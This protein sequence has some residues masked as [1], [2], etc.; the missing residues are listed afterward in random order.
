MTGQPG[1]SRQETFRIDGSD[2]MDKAKSLVDEGNKHR[3]VVRNE[4]GNDVFDIPLTVAVV[5]GIIVFPA[6]AVAA[7][8]AL[9]TRH[10]IVVESIGDAD[11]GAPPTEASPNEPG[12]ATPE[13]NPV[14]PYGADA[15]GP[16]N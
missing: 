14:P 15:S 1:A 11:A 6:T 9:A 10:S 13:T 4:H 5:G 2:L 7:I 8:A 12:E 16:L 3:L